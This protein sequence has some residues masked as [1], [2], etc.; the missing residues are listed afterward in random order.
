MI[1]MHLLVLAMPLLVLEQRVLLVDPKRGGGGGATK[2]VGI[3]IHDDDSAAE[4]RCNLLGAGRTGAVVAS[5]ETACSP[6]N[7][8]ARRI[9]SSPV[10]ACK[11]QAHA[12]ISAARLMPRRCT[13]R[14]AMHRACNQADIWGPPSARAEMCRYLSPKAKQGGECGTERALPGRAG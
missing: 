6:T 12:A 10:L 13:R 14:I 8:T 2:Q 11:A 9:F 4:Y 1:A 7:A 5:V 3:S